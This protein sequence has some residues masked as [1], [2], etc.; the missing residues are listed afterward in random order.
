M[1][2]ITVLLLLMLCGMHTLAQPSLRLMK[3]AIEQQPEGINMTLIKSTQASILFNKTSTARQSDALQ[4]L[5]TQLGLRPNTDQLKDLNSDVETGDYTIKTIQQYYKGIKVEHG[6]IHSTSARGRLAMMQLEFYSIPE[7]F[8][9]NPAIT[10]AAALE[11]AIQFVNAESYA[12]QGYTGNDPDY[13]KPKAELVIVQ[14]Y[15]AE[16]DGEVCLAYKFNIYALKPLYRAFIYVNAR[17]GKVVLDDPIIKHAKRQKLVVES[18]TVQDEIFIDE[19]N[20]EAPN[21]AS[22]AILNM[23]GIADTKGFGRKNITTDSFAST[24][25]KRYRLREFRNGHEIVTLNYQQNSHNIA[26]TPSFEQQSIDFT[27]NNNDWTSSEYPYQASN[28]RDAALDAHYS[29]EWVSDYWKN[30][31]NRNSLNNNNMGILSYVHV[32]EDGA[33]Y[34]NAYW[35][36]SNMHFGDGNGAGN[37]AATSLDD[38]AHELAHAVTETTCRLLYRWESGALNEA[39][40]DIWAACITNYTTKYEPS[41]TGEDPWRLFEKSSNTTSSLKGLR[42]MKDP[43]LFNQPDTYKST[44]WLDADRQTCPVPV[45]GGPFDNDMCG[46]H[47]NSGVLNK[48]FFLITQGQANVN[49]QGYA[50]DIKGL[51]FGETQKILYLMS[52]NLTPNAD[53]GSAMAVSLHVA[54]TLY[55]YG[56]TEHRTLM[57]AWKAVGVDSNVYTMR[58]TPVFTTN[59]FTAIGVGKDGYVFAGTN[60]SGIYRYDGIKWERLSEFTTVRTNDIKAD[61]QGGIWIAQSGQQAQ[62]SGGSSIQGGVNYIQ[63]PYTAPSIHYTIGAQTN[64]PSRNAR[65]IFVDT[66]RTNDGPNPKVWVATLAYFT[67]GNSTSGMLG[68]GQYSSG[69]AFINVNQGINVA[70][71]TAGC[72]T[73]G[74][75]ANEIWTFAQ[76]NY[77][78]NQLLRYH[79][80]T[81]QLIS[82]FDHN[83][84]PEIPSGFVARAIYGDRKKRI[85]VGLANGGVL[86]YDENQKWHHINFPEIIPANTQVNFNAIAGDQFGDVYIGTNNGLLFFDHGIGE[87]NRLDNPKCYKLFTASNGLLSNNI[88]AIAYDTLRYKFWVATDSGI[89]AWGPQCLG[90]SCRDFPRFKTTESETVM[91]GN[92][93]NPAIW[94]TGKVPDSATHVI[95]ASKIN[96]DINA[97]CLSIYVFPGGAVTMN[98]GRKIDIGAGETIIYTRQ[99]KVAGI[100]RREE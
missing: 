55:G 11:K 16:E 99:K 14:N 42:D 17:D 82:T 28:Y 1:K 26:A 59:N 83:S 29:I 27:D 41:I 32:W 50:Y 20:V 64:L 39:M 36:G 80:G 93:S 96:I 6:F 44:Y 56:S 85:W 68:Q 10:E 73:V 51:G 97:K 74:G 88:N 61:K 30:V 75:N 98:A 8:S 63:Y 67:S 72:M 13:T 54:A 2:P 70:S 18:T 84:H 4:W 34:D 53:Y 62:Q 43:T 94:N 69:R 19:Y 89:V 21:T 3:A 57:D 66:T 12:W 71:G 40:S 7:K 87:N 37:I 23:N 38:C 58:N 92:W 46:V 15:L 78:V 24:G 33:P 35:N 76:A 95:I 81:N 25:T 60:Y 77:G 47:R 86:V 49:S 100:K 48:W 91:D 65:C 31:H 79:A 22:P 5:G 45:Q 90:N 9:V 52:L